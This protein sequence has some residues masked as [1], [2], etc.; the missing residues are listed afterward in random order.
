MFLND[1]VVQIAMIDCVAIDRALVT[2]QGA[3]EANFRTNS[4]ISS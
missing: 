1:Y 2:R 4:K 3:G